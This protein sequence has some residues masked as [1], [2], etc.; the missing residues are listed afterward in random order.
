MI[1]IIGTTDQP[2]CLAAE[3]SC[4]QMLKQT[5]GQRNEGKSC[6]CIHDEHACR[7]VTDFHQSN[8]KSVFGVYT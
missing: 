5:Q 8:T 3:Y 2:C 7:A 6:A 4:D 1:A